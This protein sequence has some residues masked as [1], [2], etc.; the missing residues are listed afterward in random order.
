MI[1]KGKKALGELGEQLSCDFLVANGHRILER[2]W[3]SGHLEID[4]ISEDG[5][6]VHFVEVKS[7]T[8]PVETDPEEKVDALK[9]KKIC[10]AALRYLASGRTTGD[11]EVFFDIISVVF[12]GGSHTLRYFPEAWIPMYT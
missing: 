2:N 7:R 4:I 10:A 11:Q 1:T 3:R 6:G 12:E 8:A 5:N 9:Q